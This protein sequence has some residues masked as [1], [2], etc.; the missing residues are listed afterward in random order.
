MTVNVIQSVP[1]PDK[2]C[3]CDEGVLSDGKI[4]HGH[5]VG[6]CGNI[7]KFYCQADTGRDAPVVSDD[8]T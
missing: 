7:S 4:V 3:E 5:L 8:N 6:E 2:S 1:F